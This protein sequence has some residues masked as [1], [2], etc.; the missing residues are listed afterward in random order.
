MKCKFCNNFMLEEKI[1]LS[2]DETKPRSM[3]ARHCIYCGRIEYGTVAE[4]IVKTVT[5]SSTYFYFS[6]LVFLCLLPLC[7]SNTPQTAMR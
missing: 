2:M 3:S 1:P 7:R 6:I 5:R 4:E